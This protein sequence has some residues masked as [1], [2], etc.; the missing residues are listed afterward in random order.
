M[1]VVASQRIKDAQ[2]RYPTASQ[3]LL[4]WYQ[5]ISKGD[6]YTEKALKNTFGNLQVFNYNYKFTIPENR[7]LINALINFESQVAFIDEIKPSSY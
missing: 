7:L 3:H 4:G 1:I 2:L 5:I 6:F